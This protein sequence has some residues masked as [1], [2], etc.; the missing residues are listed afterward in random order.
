LSGPADALKGDAA[1]AVRVAE[2]LL[3]DVPVAER[4]VRHEAR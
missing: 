1:E 2:R 4:G 3:E